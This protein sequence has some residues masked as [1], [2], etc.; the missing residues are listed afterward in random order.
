MR[1]YPSIFLEFLTKTTEEHRRVGI[2][3]EII[4]VHLPSTCLE[5]YV[6]TS[7]CGVLKVRGLVYRTK[8][9]GVETRES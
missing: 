4:T 6:K 2:P 8:S 9:T 5:V 3:D 1:Y 7:L